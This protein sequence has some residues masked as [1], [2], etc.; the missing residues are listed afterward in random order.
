MSRTYCSCQFNPQKG[1]PLKLV[2]MSATLR[3]DDF[4][5]DRKLF[6]QEPPVLKIGARQFPVTIH[7]AKSTPDSYMRAAFHKVCKI[8]RSQPDGAILVFV[9]GK[10]EVNALCHKL[11]KAFPA[12]SK[13][14]TKQGNSG[15]EKESQEDKSEQKVARKPTVL[16]DILPTIN[17]DE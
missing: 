9:T 5:A 8:H 2:I 13:Q 15:A 16:G 11:R 17:L 6:K 10:Q 14:V 4:T 7:F 3:V 12:N 1:M